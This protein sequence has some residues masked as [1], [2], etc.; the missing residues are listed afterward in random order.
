VSEPAPSHEDLPLSDYDHL[1]TGSL[2]GR[3]RSLTAEQLATVRAYEEAHAHRVAVLQLLDARAAQLEQG[4]EPTSGS[5]DAARPEVAGTPETPSPASPQ[6]EGPPI[7][8]PSHGDPTNPAQ[9]RG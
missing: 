4:A 9:P 8:P 5:P 7:N 3:I 1:P 6:T 2:E